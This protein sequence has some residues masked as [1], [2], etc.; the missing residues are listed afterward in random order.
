M[1]TQRIQPGATSLGSASNGDSIYLLGGSALIAGNVDYSSVAGVAMVDVSRSYTGYFGSASAPFKAR[2]TGSMIYG[3]GGGSMYFVSA[4][5][6]GGTSALARVT[7][8]GT[9]YFVEA[10]T[11]TLVEMLSG[12]FSCAAACIVPTLR[13]AGGS[14]SIL[15]TGGTPPTLIETLP[16]GGYVLTQR[17]ATTARHAGGRMVIDSATNTVGTLEVYAP[18]CEILEA[19]TI[20]T[21]LAKGGIPDVSQLRGPLTITNSEINMALPRAKEF[22]LNPLISF[23]TTPVKLVFDGRY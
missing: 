23:S 8:G 19:G 22:L 16:A 9:L 3:A 5:T 13:V 15:G 14:A 18:G 7:G 12:G 11:I 6:G 21:L 1:A 2:I 4:S 17:G 20:T 10:G